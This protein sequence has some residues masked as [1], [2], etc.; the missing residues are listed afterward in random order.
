V[1]S[2]P[3]FLILQNAIRGVSGLSQP[4]VSID[5]VRVFHN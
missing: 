5:W 4:V 2:T 1:P 3:Q